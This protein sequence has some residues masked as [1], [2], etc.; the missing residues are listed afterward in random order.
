[1]LLPAS[2]ERRK[3]L[4]KITSNY[5]GPILLGIINRSRAALQ[6]DEGRNRQILERIPAGRWG[7]PEDVAGPCRFPFLLGE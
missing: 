4:G 1:M 6:A 7:E 3:Q 5:S 2:C